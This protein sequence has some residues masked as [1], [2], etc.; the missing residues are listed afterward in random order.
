MSLRIL[1]LAFLLLAAC[2]EPRAAEETA[3]ATPG[4]PPAAALTRADAGTQ[5]APELPDFDD[6]RRFL[7]LDSLRWAEVESPAS[8]DWVARLRAVG[9]TLIRSDS[10][11]EREPLDAMSSD[12]D[13]NGESTLHFHFV[14]FS[15][16]GTDDVIYS[17]PWFERNENGFGALEGTRFRLY[18]VMNG[19][20]V[21]VLD[22]PGAVQRIFRGGRGQPASFRAVVYGCCSDPQWEIDYYRPVR[23][24]DTVRF[25]AYRRISGRQGLVAPSRFLQSRRAFTVNNDRYLLRESPGIDPAAPDGEDWFRW[26]GRGNALAEYAR[27]ARGVALAER[28]DSTGRVWWFVLMD[29]RT[30][31]RD[32]Q[33]A[34]PDG[35][36][37]RMDRLG[38]MSSRFLTPDP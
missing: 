36:P 20:A 1:P 28:A 38:W 8:G 5:T 4:S 24:G 33:I 29:G 2:S 23:A 14:D 13:P 17:G 31:P 7:D 22:R 37:V 11:G 30:A 27:G 6:P 9:I 10:T 16:D 32:A 18:Q 35:D 19:R 15:G 25:E 12:Y 21:Q 34:P 3:P 26:E